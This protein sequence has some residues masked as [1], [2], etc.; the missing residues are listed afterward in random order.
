MLA[1]IKR[2]NP[3]FPVFNDFFGENFLNDSD[4]NTSPAVNI[5]ENKDGFRIEVAA[6]GLKKED[7]KINID[8]RML[9]ISSEKET[10]VES[11]NKEVKEGED[12]YYR[13]EF[14]YSSFKRTFTLPSYADTDAIKANY[15]DGILYVTV[16]K[17]EEAKEKPSRMIS[18]E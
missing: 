4:W 2:Q 1:T 11:G 17:K 10:T 9:E 15:N 8:K 6:P 18:I 12:R 16:P 5:A 3:F 14:S 13:K 7:F